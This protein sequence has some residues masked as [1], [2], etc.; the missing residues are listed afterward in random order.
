MNAIKAKVNSTY[1]I[2]YRMP[3]HK[4]GTSCEGAQG[5]SLAEAYPNVEFRNLEISGMHR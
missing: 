2:V 1:H 3:D 5:L 4:G